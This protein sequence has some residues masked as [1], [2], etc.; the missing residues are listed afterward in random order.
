M[1]T[2][3][4]RRRIVMAVSD[5]LLTDQRVLRASDALYEAGY[6][7]SLVGRAWPDKSRLVKPYRSCKMRLLFKRSAFFYA[8]FNIR[9]FL[10]LLFSRADVF[11]AN[12]T[13][14]LLGVGVAA[15][16]RGKQFVFD[17]H[18]LFPDVPELVDKPLV[19]SVWRAIE[20]VFIKRAALCITVNES[21][22]RE[23]R[24]RYGVEFTV[25]RNLSAVSGQLSAVSSQ[26]SAVSDTVLL[27]QGAVNRGR[28][29]KEVI[30]AMEFLQDCR[31]V[32][33]GGGDLLD[34]MKRYAAGKPYASRIVFTGRL[35]PEV[36]REL[37]G[38]AKLGFCIMENMGLNY[39]L[40]L[41]NRIADYAYSHVPVL[42]NDF[43]EMRRVLDAYRIGSCIDEEVIYDA[44]RL[45]GE[46]RKVLEEW[47]S[48][49]ADE[50]R[51]RFEAALEDMSWKKEQKKL[52][53]HIDTIFL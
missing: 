53:D 31:F 52:I 13:D 11:Y 5:D 22:A 50:R 42:A 8:E 38:Q 37:T 12:D 26:Q 7:V 6:E 25:V 34:E 49:G 18:E 2:A 35:R 21:L 27:Y 43:P 39:Y 17:G 20:R 16:L 24:R 14:S 29:V 40:S 9:L 23:Y 47:G 45:A 32:V 28:C 3:D 30:D 41:P 4:Y 1:E 46:A 36:L 48:M 10:K 51:T 15:W 44:R 19:R 33:A